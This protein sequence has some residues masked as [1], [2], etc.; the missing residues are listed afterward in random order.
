MANVATNLET[1]VVLPYA[2][3]AN[4]QNHVLNIASSRLMFIDMAGASA[5]RTIQLPSTGVKAGERF[6]LEVTGAT[7]SFYVRLNASNGTQ[8]DLI[9]GRGFIEVMATSD[10]PAGAGSWYILDL[11]ENYTFVYTSGGFSDTREV[12]RSGDGTYSL[13]FATSHSLFAVTMTQVGTSGIYRTG[14]VT[15]QFGTTV[16]GT[17]LRCQC[18]GS[19]NGGTDIAANPSTITATTVRIVFTANSTQAQI[20]YGMQF[21]VFG[22]WR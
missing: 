12:N 7:D 22:N 15:Y 21:I 20:A 16:P 1:G 3:L 17:R 19:D 13:K 4:T 9:R 10:N 2:V 14:G 11:N 6:R 18:G 5:L 8:I